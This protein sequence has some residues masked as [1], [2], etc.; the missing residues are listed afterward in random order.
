MSNITE[1]ERSEEVRRQDAAV[2]ASDSEV[3]LA[4]AAARMGIWEWDLNSDAVKWSSATVLAHGLT[5]ETVPTTGRAAFELVH[6]DDR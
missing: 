6:P 3:W 1:P 2:P 5:P 4:L